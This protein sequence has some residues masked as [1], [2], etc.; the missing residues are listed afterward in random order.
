V[1]SCGGEAAGC[2]ELCD[3][4]YAAR[5]DK[6]I[7]AVVDSDSYSAAYAIASAASRIVVTPSGGA[8]SIG[9]VAMHVSYEKMLEEAGLKVT[10]IF[11]GDH[12]VDGNP[13]Q[14][15]PDTVKAD[16]QA[17]VNKSRDAFVAQVARNRGLD[18]QAVL[19]T[20]AR[21]YRA[22]DA[23][24]LGLIDAVQPPNQAVQAFFD[25]LPGSDTN[26]E[27]AMANAEKKPGVENADTTA[28]VDTTKIA[29]DARLAERER[30]DGITGCD[31][32]KT[33]PA[34]ASH[35]AFKTDMSV[36]D[37]K[38]ML[39]AAAS[40]KQETASVEKPV[41]EGASAFNA[42]MDKSE[43][44][45]VGAGGAGESGS[46]NEPS[47]TARILAAQERATGRKVETKH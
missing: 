30:M 25:E 4:I 17:R 2:F 19:D 45:N 35:I 36:D 44:P 43:H 33:R 47:A 29:A 10:Y 21:I 39:A 14:D 15:L 38:V 13:Y 37:A 27:Q 12:K 5:A 42:A 24:G 6:P 40:E 1:N 7:M 31:E 20:Q 18:P 11:A 46:G 8:G 3:D 22:D 16:I 9:V 32:A 41:K 26:Q 23:L 34:L 28:E